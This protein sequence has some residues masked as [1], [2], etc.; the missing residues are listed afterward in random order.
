MIKCKDTFGE[1]YEKAVD[2]PTVQI[3]MSGVIHKR[4][5]APVRQQKDKANADK[6]DKNFFI[7]EQEELVYV[8]I[9]ASESS[10]KVDELSRKSRT[11][12]K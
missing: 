12:E 5:A 8:D 1:K 9:D 4:N 2:F 11:K 7:V 3:L 10:V 6:I